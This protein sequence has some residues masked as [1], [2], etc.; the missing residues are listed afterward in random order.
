MRAPL[1][2][3]LL[4]HR[5]SAEIAAESAAESAGPA[6]A[7]ASGFSSV[8]PGAPHVRVQDLGITRGDG[9]FE[10]ISVCGGNA[11]AL[12]PHL[13]RFAHS[14]AMLDLP[15]PDLDAYRRAVLASVEEHEAVPELLVKIVLTRGVE[16]GGI[17]TGW[18]Y[19]EQAADYSAARSDGIRVV[20]LD[21][22]YRHDVA[23]TSPWLLQGAKT[24]SYAVNRA[25][26]RE[27]E[28][29]GAH[30]VIFVSSDGYV[31]EGPTSSVLLK[32]GNTLVTPKT[33]Q[34]ILE[35]TTQASVFDYARSIGL[36]TEY[37][38]VRP[39]E[40]AEADALWLVSSGRQ[41]APVNNVDGG[42][43]PMDADLSRGILEYLLAR[44]E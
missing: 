25:V 20:T 29:R 11:Q 42:D 17:P 39:D 4:L 40:L 13:T 12:E 43:R 33:D 3:L 19:T 18:V 23:Q 16:G 10:S 32:R 6:A 37:A 34:G 1:P 8:D 36:E 21:R 31:L 7:A 28:R 24:L 22:G 44:T 5:P 35:G 9:I 27:A 30:D 14:A 41:S 15:A 38:L 26:L 2:V